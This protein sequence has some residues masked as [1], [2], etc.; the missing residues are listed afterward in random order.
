LLVSASMRSQSKPKRCL[1]NAEHRG[2][3]LTMLI[4]TLIVYKQS[5][6]QYFSILQDALIKISFALLFLLSLQA[7]YRVAVQV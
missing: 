4:R 3:C 7:V 6:P 2:T 5:H 1:Q